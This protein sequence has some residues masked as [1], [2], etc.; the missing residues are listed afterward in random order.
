[1]LVEGNAGDARLVREM[2]AEAGAL[3]FDLM[4]VSRLSDALKRL[5][6]AE[7]DAVLLDLNLPDAR[8]LQAIAPVSDTA[9][10]VPIVVLSGLWDE[11]LAVAAVQRGAQDYLVKGQGGASLLARSIR[12]AIER[13]QSE[14]YISYLAYHDTLTNLP[15]RRLLLDRLEQALALERRNQSTLALVF[16]GL[17]DFKHIND[18]LG[19]SAGDE[20][21]KSVAA[22]LRGCVRQSDTIARIGGDEFAM[23]LPDIDRPDDA[24]I[25]A[26]KILSALEAPFYVAGEEL[27]VTASVGISLFPDDAREAEA[28]LRNADV[29]MYRSKRIEGNTSSFYSRSVDSRTTERLVLSSDLRRAIERGELLVHYQPLVDLE[30]GRTTA[31]EALARWQHPVLGLIPPTVFIPLAE[32]TGL[33]TRVGAWV[34]RSACLEACRWQDE[35]LRSIGVSV[36][37]SSQQFN[38]AGLLDTVIQVLEETGMEPSLLEL[39]LTESGIMRNPESAITTL[40]GLRSLGVRI[41]VD[42]FGTGYSSLSHLKRLP[43]DG[44]KIDRSFV[45]DATR[46]S[47]DAGIVRAIITMAH[48]LKMQV[49]AEGV[50]M[51]SQV[52]FLRELSCDRAQGFYFSPPLPR[53]AL[54]KM[55]EPF[56]SETQIS[57]AFF[58][59]NH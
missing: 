13:K 5:K 37:L 26:E 3:P 50:T 42:D 47:I 18:T 9:P 33:I 6:E 43:I 19:H 12:Y 39:E 2:L 7:F 45:M 20:L 16:L 41:H 17:D 24:R 59:R 4:H 48:G 32:E 40:S 25:F 1:M 30:S 57:F 35:G 38:Q 46:E 15:N 21:L 29:A 36:N 10:D 34:L 52:D 31:F 28:L 23:I 58:G 49:T 14:K 51:K 56:F 53:P 27:F 44:L 55:I 22:R 54:A 11:S 8:G